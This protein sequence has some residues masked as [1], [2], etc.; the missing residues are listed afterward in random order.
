MI[1]RL[2]IETINLKDKAAKLVEIDKGFKTF[3]SKRS[4][5]M[6]NE[7]IDINKQVKFLDNQ[8]KELDQ[9][10]KTIH[11]FQKEAYNKHFFHSLIDKRQTPHSSHDHE[12]KIME[13]ET[14]RAAHNE[15][16][17]TIKLES[18]LK[19]IDELISQ[20]R[21][22]EAKLNSQIMKLQ[23]INI[24]KR[25]NK[26]HISMKP[27]ISDNISSLQSLTKDMDNQKKKTSE[28]IQKNIEDLIK[29]KEHYENKL[30]FKSIGLKRLESNDLKYSFIDDITGARYKD[31]LKREDKLKLMEGK[32]ADDE[33]FVN[34]LKENN[35]TTQSTL[36]NNI[37]IMRLLGEQQQAHLI[38][39][40]NEKTDYVN[41]SYQRVKDLEDNLKQVAKIGEDERRHRLKNL[42]DLNNHILEKERAGLA[43]TK[44]NLIKQGKELISQMERHDTYYWGH[45]LT[46]KQELQ[47]K[48]S[49]LKKKQDMFKDQN[50]LILK[51]IADKKE[52]I[53]HLETRLKEKELN[54][55][56]KKKLIKER[57]QKLDQR[58]NTVQELLK[59]T[60]I[61]KAELEKE[62]NDLYQRKQYKKMHDTFK[63][64]PLYLGTSLPPDY[65]ALGDSFISVEKS[66]HAMTGHL[67]L[68]RKENEK[69]IQLINEITEL[70]KSNTDELVKMKQ[71]VDDKEQQSKT[72]EEEQRVET[73]KVEAKLVEAMDELAKVKRERAEDIKQHKEEEARAVESAKKLAIA[74]DESRKRREN[75]LAGKRIRDLQLKNADLVKELQRHQQVVKNIVSEHTNDLNNNRA[76]YEKLIESR[77]EVFNKDREEIKKFYDDLQANNDWQTHNLKG[78]YQ[79]L[80]ENNDNKL[81]DLTMLYTKTQEDSQAI[82]KEYLDDFWRRVKYTEELQADLEECR[83]RDALWGLELLNKKA[84]MNGFITQAERDESDRLRKLD[85][86][87]DAEKKANDAEMARLKDEIEIIRVEATNERLKILLE[88]NKHQEENEI[89][90]K[91]IAETT[92]LNLSF[93]QFLNAERDFPIYRPVLI[94]K[95]YEY[96]R[97]ERLSEVNVKDIIPLDAPVG[98]QK[99]VGGLI[100]TNPHASVGDL[101]VHLTTSDSPLKLKV[102]PIE[103]D[104]SPDIYNFRDRVI[105]RLSIQYEKRMERLPEPQRI[106]LHNALERARI[107]GKNDPSAQ[108]GLIFFLTAMI[109]AVLLESG[110]SVNIPHVVEKAQYAVG[111]LGAMA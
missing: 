36:S 27:V 88:L 50:K 102:E 10:N 56:I 3:T 98:I 67:E 73:E 63:P 103:V 99:L 64:N 110:G 13:M 58:D 1:R 109:G 49:V 105:D 65:Y 4:L 83:K 61:M 62:K 12:M 100:F 82:K 74:T 101:I 43:Q 85:Q 23:G 11:S 40:F 96:H 32:L 91:S 104:P 46:R 41:K 24:R 66:L 80:L 45:D 33:I 25:I 21:E 16:Q 76:N 69:K 52:Y 59:K 94:D 55:D 31:I 70:Q 97:F 51:G 57:E 7:Q 26:K 8:R 108:A 22:K 77:L 95:L 44:A 48:E 14:K 28:L 107:D 60:N 72:R 111:V 39:E 6:F 29:A 93:I 15:L 79:A 42:I 90:T 53:T 87:R 9:I 86:E 89:L 54:L 17:L 30:Y 47:H 18:S 34:A 81:S 84:A 78:Y 68:A 5:E 38:S 71:I 106:V 92:E 37:K 20:D 35:M 75:L 19:K 2:N